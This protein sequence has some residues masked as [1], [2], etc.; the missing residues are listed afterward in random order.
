MEDE[1]IKIGR[2][3]TKED[4]VGHGEDLGFYSKHNGKL[5]SNFEHVNKISNSTDFKKH[6]SEIKNIF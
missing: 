4:L 5:L 2:S 1:I 3:H 6:V